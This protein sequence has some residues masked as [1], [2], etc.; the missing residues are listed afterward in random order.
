MDGGIQM[1]TIYLE[2][3]LSHIVNI[4]NR[5]GCRCFMCVFTCNSVLIPYLTSKTFYAWSIPGFRILV[6]KHCLLIYLFF[7]H[8]WR[9]FVLCLNIQFLRSHGEEGIIRINGIY[10]CTLERIIGYFMKCCKWW[11]T[12]ILC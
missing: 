4:F 3:N 9:H 6:S 5:I 1:Q 2:M 10:I 12:W 7:S 11:V 8:G